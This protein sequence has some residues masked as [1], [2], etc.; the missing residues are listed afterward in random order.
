MPQHWGL[1]FISFYPDESPLIV[2]S[3]TVFHGLGPSFLDHFAGTIDELTSCMLSRGKAAP[4]VEKSRVRAEGVSRW[5][6][7]SLL[8]RA[9]YVRRGRPGDDIC[10]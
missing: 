2:E 8:I 6:I 1:T 10:L 9:A 7:V 3:H 4:S 5:C